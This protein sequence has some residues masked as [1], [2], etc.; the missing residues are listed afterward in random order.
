MRGLL[1]ALL[2]FDRSGTAGAGRRAS[3]LT[4]TPAKTTTKAV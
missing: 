2:A 1:L 3:A 4:T